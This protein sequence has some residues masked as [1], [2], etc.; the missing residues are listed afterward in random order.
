[1][2]G[3]SSL[4][5]KDEEEKRGR[6]T[7]TPLP[8]DEMQAFTEVEVDGGM[9]HGEPRPEKPRRQTYGWFGARGRQLSRPEDI[10]A[11]QARRTLPAWSDRSTIVLALTVILLTAAQLYLISLAKHYE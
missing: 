2:N 4:E 9:L 7:D 3:A 8:R 5:E 10:L 1:M 6:T 11:E